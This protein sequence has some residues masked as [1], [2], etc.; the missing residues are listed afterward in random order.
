MDNL[1]L[2]LASLLILIICLIVWLNNS[3][4]YV[5]QPRLIKWIALVAMLSTIYFYTKLEKNDIDSI[6]QV[7]GGTLDN[8]RESLIIDLDRYPD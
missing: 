7:S 1:Q 6:L 2:L 5:K 4:N 3:I 8:E